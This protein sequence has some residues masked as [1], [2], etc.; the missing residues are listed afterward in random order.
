MKKLFPILVSCNQIYVVARRETQKK[1]DQER[2]HSSG[3][4]ALWL[5]SSGQEQLYIEPALF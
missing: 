4:R 5:Y 3:S 1:K 2:Q